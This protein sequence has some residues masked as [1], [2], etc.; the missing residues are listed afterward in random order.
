MTTIPVEEFEDDT[1]GNPLTRRS[2]W[3][4]R[5]EAWGFGQ[6]TEAGLLM[7]DE[8]YEEAVGGGQEQEGFGL[9]GDG[10]G[11]DE[12]DENDEQYEVDGVIDNRNGDSLLSKQGVGHYGDDGGGGAFQQ[13][14]KMHSQG[15]I[16]TSESFQGTSVVFG[17]GGGGGFGGFG[18]G[19]LAGGFGGGLATAG[20]GVGAGGGGRRRGS[21]VYSMSHQFLYRTPLQR[22]RPALVTAL[23][24]ILAANTQL[25]VVNICFCCF[26][27]YVGARS[28]DYLDHDIWQACLVRVGR[29]DREKDLSF[30][31]AA[32]GYG[33]QVKYFTF[34]LCDCCALVSLCNTSFSCRL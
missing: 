17:T 18:G 25:C 33:C 5:L 13:Q 24:C 20:A 12:N 19:G 27:A 14:A 21:S 22:A 6:T 16:R 4:D 23:R 2:T 7:D 9:G 29:F 26:Y 34:V 8:E 11:D 28:K 15:S 31:S 32:T 10:D 3:M 30:V 1:F